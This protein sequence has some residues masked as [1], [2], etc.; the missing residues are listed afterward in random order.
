MSVEGREQQPK[1]LPCGKNSL[2]P[3]R[4]RFKTKQSRL[5][6]IV[7]RLKGCA[8]NTLAHYI[9]RD[10]MLESWRRLNKRSAAGLDRVSADGFAENLEE[11][12]AELLEEMIQG[13][14]QPKPLK[15]VNIPKD[16]GKTRP[17]GLPTIKDK[18]A[19]QAVTIILTEIYEKEF[20]NMSY[21]YRPGKSTHDA[22]NGIKHAVA[23]GKVS[24]VVDI[25]IKSFFDTM[26]HDWLM[27]F[28]KHKIQ[29]KNILRLIKKWLKSGVME[30]NKL[31]RTS[32]GTP[33]GG[34]VSPVLAN[35]YLHYVLD[36][37]VTKVVPK[38]ISGEMY[39][40]RYADDCLF[41]FQK[42]EDAM[43][44]KEALG[45]RL[46]KF[47]LELNASK[48]KLCRFGR[49]AETNRKRAGE[50]RQSLQFLGF[51]LYNKTSRIGKY[52]VGCRTSSKKLCLAMNNVTRWCKEH[53][54]Q[55]IEWQARYLNA[56]LRGHYNYYGVTHN[57]QSINAFY[58]H[59]Q[60]A[61]QRYLSKRSQR[62][63]IKWK[64]FWKLLKKYPLIEPHLPKAVTW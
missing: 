26:D 11:N 49:F 57:F 27:T 59:V 19:Q 44:F 63:Y 45:N 8:I 15:R 52:T 55:K 38:Y 20:L 14:Y 47:K 28:L 60:W 17:L 58:R 46:N 2:P 16:N 54:H 29:D 33:Q 5:A 12:I 4:I 3:S 35:I 50:K 10:W 64:D 61:W 34:V 36:L 53:R 22:I 51:T 30:E 21:G 18:L 1:C 56:V 23:R 42:F 9:D 32:T 13:S 6:T 48:S 31:L 24:W 39:A 7:Q 37:W 62:A 41:C 43:K 25:D 40:F